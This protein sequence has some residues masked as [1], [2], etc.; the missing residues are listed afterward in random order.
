M[1][2][3]YVSSARDGGTDGAYEQHFLETLRE[4]GVEVSEL[5]HRCRA[6]PWRGGRR[7]QGVIERFQ[8][9]LMHVHLGYGLLFQALARSHIPTIFTLHNTRLSFP[10][11]LFRLFDLF[12]DR[13]VAICAP[14]EVMLKQC[15]RR[16]VKRIA[17]GSPVPANGRASPRRYP[18]SGITILSVGALTAQKGYPTLIHAAA[19]I[20]PHFDAKGIPIR[21]LIAGEGPKHALLQAEIDK[22]G[23]SKR[24]L[25][26]GT[27]IEVDAL[28]AE[29][30]LMVMSSR[31][32]GLPIALLEGHQAGLPIVATDVGGCNEI[33]RQ[34]VSGWLVPPGVPE[35]LADAIEWALADVARYEEMSV[36]ALASDETFGMDRCVDLHLALYRDV[37]VERRQRSSPPVR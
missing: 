13:N 14:C 32:E 33:V 3:C 26:L 19:R 4:H 28:M 12:I 10:K 24:V 16:P 21:F 29:S 11:A 9:D 22:L 7:L 36:Q 31:Y 27:R 2:I 6:L 30:D 18:R 37:L 23:L 34:G 15:S 25:L 35:A 8:P 20:V 17:N 5:G 1:M